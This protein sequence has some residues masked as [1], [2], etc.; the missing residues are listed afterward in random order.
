[1]RNPGR[2]SEMTSSDERT[3][4]PRQID[5]LGGWGRPAPVGI[6]RVLTGYPW[7]GEF[8]LHPDGH[9]LTIGATWVICADLVAELD[10]HDRPSIVGLRGLRSMIRYRGRPVDAEA[11]SGLEGYWRPLMLIPAGTKVRVEDV[12]GSIEWGWGGIVDSFIQFSLTGGQR[13]VLRTAQAQGELWLDEALAAGRKADE[14][15]TGMS[16]WEIACAAV[17]VPITHPTASDPAACDAILARVGG[18]IPGGG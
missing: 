1:M 7:M 3:K 5:D 18:M 6:E 8:H 4:R 9:D 15:V 2:L 16:W 11:V 10:L 13:F 14:I 12:S 17:V